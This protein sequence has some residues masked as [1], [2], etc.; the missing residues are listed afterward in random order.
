[1]YLLVFSGVKESQGHRMGKRRKPETKTFEEVEGQ[2]DWGWEVKHGSGQLVQGNMEEHTWAGGSHPS[3]P[4]TMAEMPIEGANSSVFNCTE[5]MVAD[6]DQEAPHLSGQGDAMR[7]GDTEQTVCCHSGLSD[8]ENVPY[9]HSYDTNPPK[10]P[11]LLWRSGSMAH[12]VLGR[13]K[14]ARHSHTWE[15]PSVCA[16]KRTF[17]LAGEAFKKLIQALLRGAGHL[18]FEKLP[19]VLLMDPRGLRITDLNQP[20]LIP[21]KRR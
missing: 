19:Q 8:P 12:P 16:A 7:G 2:K 14:K 5:Q 11:A 6:H 17:T 4:W 15:D 3:L 20:S 1:M 18:H 9:N 10:G 21:N 13:E